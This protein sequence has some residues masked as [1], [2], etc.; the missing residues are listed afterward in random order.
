MSDTADEGFERSKDFRRMNI[1][2]IKSKVYYLINL[3]IVHVVAIVQV[4]IWGEMFEFR[5]YID[6]LRDLQ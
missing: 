2:I 3:I 1:I 4:V 5:D 6:S